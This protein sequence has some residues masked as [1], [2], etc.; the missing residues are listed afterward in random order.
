MDALTCSGLPSCQTTVQIP[1]PSVWI[2]LDSY[3]PSRRNTQYH[4]MTEGQYG[5][6]R[7]ATRTLTRGIHSI[8][9]H[10]F[11]GTFIK[12]PMRLSTAEGNLGG[13][14]FICRNKEP[15]K[16]SGPSKDG[17]LV[18]RV[19]PTTTRRSTALH[20]DIDPYTVVS[21]D[22]THLFQRPTSH[23]LLDEKGEQRQS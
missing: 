12:A 3:S 15:K 5:E 23:S 1:L 11:V 9:Y 18:K 20:R 10:D 4:F 7:R 2:H 6:V 16:S 17:M 8:G 22:Q 19:S 13:K 14:L 21:L